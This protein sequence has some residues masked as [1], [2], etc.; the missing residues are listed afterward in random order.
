MV[1]RAIIR[2]AQQIS[3]NGKIKVFS[4]IF[5]QTLGLMF[6]KPNGY[7]YVFS[8]SEDKTWV[9]HTFFCHTM[10]MYFLDAK[11][12][13]V[14]KKNFVLPFSVVKCPYPYRY[15]IERFVC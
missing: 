10:H 6:K 1:S 12:K 2:K 3:K 5:S 13:V 8:F 4:H 15:V 7:A 9:F 14:F 11:G